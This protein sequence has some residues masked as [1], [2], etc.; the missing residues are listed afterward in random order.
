VGVSLTFGDP[1]LLLEKETLRITEDF[2]FVTEELDYFD[3]SIRPHT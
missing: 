2:D 1:N 3:Q